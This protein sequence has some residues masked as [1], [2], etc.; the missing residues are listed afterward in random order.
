[1]QRRF[2]FFS[3][4]FAKHILFFSPF[5]W[6]VAIISYSFILTQPS[7]NMLDFLLF[8]SSASLVERQEWRPSTHCLKEAFAKHAR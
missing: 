3:I 1:M 7:V 2:L 6:M 8:Q 4:F 5:L